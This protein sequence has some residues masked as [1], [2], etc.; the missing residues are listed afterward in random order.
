MCEKIRFTVSCEKSSKDLPLGTM[1]L[2]SVWFFSTCGFWD[3]IMGSQKKTEI[4][5][6]P[7]GS[8]SKEKTS[9]NSPPLS[10]RITGMTVAGSKP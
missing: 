6:C 1:S 4:S 7:F 9:E 3:D 8:F 2:K 10:V 5:F